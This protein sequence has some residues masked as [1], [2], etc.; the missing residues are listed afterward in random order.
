NPNSEIRGVF[1]D[2]V[3][4]GSLLFEGQLYGIENAKLHIPV[5]QTVSRT[6]EQQMIVYRSSDMKWD[7]RQKHNGR[8]PSFCG[9]THVKQKNSKFGNQHFVTKNTNTGRH[10]RH[11]REGSTPLW[12]TCQII[13]VAD[14][15][16]F[17]GI[18]D[19]DV[20]KTALHMANVMDHVDKIYRS[21]EFHPGSPVRGLGFEIAEMDIYE[22]STSGF[23]NESQAWDP[24]SLLQAFSRNLDYKDFCAAHLFT[25]QAFEGNVLGLAYIAPPREGGVGG[26]CSPVARIENALCSLNTGWSSSQN[27]N[28]EP[29]L[30]QQSDLV[31][32][33]ELGHNWG[34]E[35][36]TDSGECSPSFGKGK[37]LMYPYSVS[38]YDSNNYL[39]SPCSKDL[40]SS[41]LALKGSSCLEQ[42]ST[43]ENQICGNG[44]LDPGE[45]CDAGF[46]GRFMLDDC[47]DSFCKLLGNATCSPVNHE[48]CFD[49]AVATAGTTC[50]SDNEIDCFK[51]AVCKYPFLHLECQEPERK[52][53][54]EAC[55]DEGQCFSGECLPFCEARGLITCACENLASACQRCCRANNVSECR[56]FDN[57]HPLPDGRSCIQGYCQGAVCRSSTASTIERLFDILED[58][59]VDNIVQFFR[60]NIVGCVIVFSL[61][62]WIP[63]CIIISC[64][65]RQIRR[66]IDRNENFEIR[67]LSIT[68]F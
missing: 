35:H 59:H 4:S 24:L 60:N 6:Y 30:Q 63:I 1:I 47:C 11:K 38:G 36:D 7:T 43:D 10:K 56:Q 32:A 53:D 50:R 66:Q 3:F 28:G 20:Y 44:K 16:F 61:L 42:K 34:A 12:N 22:A 25:H 55:L 29:V 13:T 54:R 21:T 26:I 2:G 65:D 14:Y 18:G 52:A 23:N 51:T 31:T 46:M 49:C 68:S 39:F 37:F 19:S 9:N 41:V 45:Q 15:K 8:G 17:R 62:L 57:K 58:L 48:C 64:K 40:I 67:T 33:H 5:D 27:Q